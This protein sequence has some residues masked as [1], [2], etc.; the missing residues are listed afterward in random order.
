M[1]CPAVCP[2]VVWSPSGLRPGPVPL[3]HLHKWPAHQYAPVESGVW[4]PS[5]LRPGPVPLSHLHNWPA[6][7]YQDTSPLICW[8]H[9]VQQWNSKHCRPRHSPS[10]PWL[11]CWVG[12][13]MGY[14]VPPSQILHPQRY[15][16]LTKIWTIIPTPWPATWECT[17]NQVPWSWDTRKPQ[18]EQSHHLHHKQGQQNSWLCT[19]KP[20]SWEQTYKRDRMQGTYQTEA[21][22]CCICMGSTHPSGHQNTGKGATQ[23]SAL[24]YQPLSTNF[25][26]QFHPDRSRL[27]NTSKQKEKIMTG[28]ILQTSQRPDH[29]QLQSPTNSIQQQTQFEKKNNSSCY[30]IPRSRTRYRQMSFFPRTIPEWNALPEE[31]T[32]AELLDIF[33]SKLTPRI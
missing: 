14:A 18:M 7:Q 9:H 6:H 3:S 24:G 30:D 4:S 26:R 5:G 11:I 21:W 28:I 19:Q 31:I 15:Q 17:N 25:L 12:N 22:V 33:R 1:T 29:H 16:K 23:S 13:Q 8:W 2:G 10:W 20:E 27:A 32:E